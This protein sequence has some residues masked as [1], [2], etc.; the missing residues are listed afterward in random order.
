MFIICL[1]V[2]CAVC[3]AFDST[4]WVG[5]A[6]LTLLLYLFPAYFT[7]LAAIAAVGFFLYHYFN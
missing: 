3:L 5:L 2:F 7:G 6:G 4:R 1:L